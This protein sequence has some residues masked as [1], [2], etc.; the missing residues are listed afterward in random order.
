[1]NS[2]SGRVDFARHQSLVQTVR[3]MRKSFPSL[4]RSSGVTSNPVNNGKGK[5]SARAFICNW[6]Y[7]VIVTVCFLCA[8]CVQF[9]CDLCAIFMRLNAY[10]RVCRWISFRIM[11][12]PLS[13]SCELMRVKRIH[14]YINDK[15][16]ATRV[17]LSAARAVP[18][19]PA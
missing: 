7:V 14:F 17:P 9:V 12:S 5:Y 1:M 8:I 11:F 15:Y 16:C 18:T 13:S 2:L 6:V 10:A 3:S 19:A 4:T